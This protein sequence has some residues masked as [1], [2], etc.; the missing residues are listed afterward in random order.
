[1]G[2]RDD[3]ALR[4]GQGFNLGVEV[5]G[6]RLDDARSETGLWAKTPSGL[7]IPLSAT[8]SFQ[9]V[10]S[11]SYATVILPFIFSLGNACFRAFMTSSVVIKPILSASRELKLPAVPTT[12]SVTG[13]TSPIIDAARAS[14]SLVR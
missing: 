7:P 6:E 11:A 10:P 4:T 9:F 8:E 14:P 13:R 1:M 2:D 12:F 5:M 3:C